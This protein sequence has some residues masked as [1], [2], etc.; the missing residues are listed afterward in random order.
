MILADVR[1]RLGR[2]D[3]QLALRLIARGSSAEQERGEEALRDG[4]IDAL[5]DD[6]RL[7]PALL[8]SRHGAHASFPLF[9]YVVVRHALRRAG[10]D[11]RVLA[12]YVAAILLHFG[13]RDRAHRVSDADDERYDTLAALTGDVDG[14]DARRAF[15]VRQHLGN[16]ALW[17]AGLVPRRPGPGLLRR[18]RAP[19]LP[20]GGR[21]PAGRRA[22]AR[23]AVPP[24]RGALPNAPRGAQCR[25]RHAPVPAPQHA[26]APDATGEGRGAVDGALSGP[27]PR[28]PPL[29]EGAR[30]LYPT[31]ALGRRGPLA[32]SALPRGAPPG[33]RPTRS[34]APPAC[35]R[36]SAAP[37][38]T[39]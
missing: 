35:S 5:L 9:A 21:P 30:G 18:A 33:R 22:R 13:V 39:C 26:G 32:T 23:A 10:E 37:W 4:G 29:R 14:P 8:E 11:D 16:Y 1:R 38:R 19:R 24:R 7:L 34:H 6:P 3:A 36:S 15:L 17:M 2:E 28:R 12:D 31:A 20:H 25:E 27:P